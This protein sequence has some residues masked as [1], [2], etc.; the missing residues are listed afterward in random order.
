MHMTTPG[1]FLALM[2]INET[3]G[4]QKYGEA[5]YASMEGFQIEVLVIDDAP[6]LLEGQAVGQHIVLLKFES[7]AK[8][9][10]WY[11]SE[12]YNVAKPFRQQSCT[13]HAIL[14]LEGFTG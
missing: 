5:G 1:Y 9:Q 11:E 4:F 14:A 12:G 8:L 3:E 2:D 6:T 13:T 10:E 7:K